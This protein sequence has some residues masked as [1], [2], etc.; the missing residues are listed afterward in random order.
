MQAVLSVP[1][2]A[3]LPSAHFVQDPVPSVAKLAESAHT[4]PGKQ[5]MASAAPVPLQV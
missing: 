2:G 4:Y 5:E 1:P 3:P